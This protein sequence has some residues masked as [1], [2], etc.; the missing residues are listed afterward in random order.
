MLF[1]VA[2]SIHMYIY[3]AIHFDSFGE[4]RCKIDTTEFI[5]YLG[6]GFN[7]DFT[8]LKL[9]RLTIVRIIISRKNT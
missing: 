2:P 3:E 6:I 4:V 7:S 9:G 5:Q 1:F 8:S